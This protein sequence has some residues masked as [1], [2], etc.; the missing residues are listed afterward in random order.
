M[1]AMTHSHPPYSTL[2]QIVEEMGQL[3]EAGIDGINIVWPGYERG[4]EQ[5]RD[6]ILPLT[7]VAGLRT[8]D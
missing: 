7:L 2:A 1:V 5:L 4:I 3:S 8:M 6:E